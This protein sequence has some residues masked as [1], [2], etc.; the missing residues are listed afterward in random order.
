M[1]VAFESAL[2]RVFA[3]CEE[4]IS[5]HL[6]KV[7]ARSQALQSQD[8][9]RLAFTITEAIEEEVRA[10]LDESLGIYDAAINRPITPNAGWEK[11]LLKQV[12]YAVDGAVI[13][14][15][16]L[17]SEK[18]PWKPLLSEEAPKLRERLSA[19][20][21]AHFAELRKARKTRR[22]AAPTGLPETLVRLALFVGGVVVGAIA[23]NVIRL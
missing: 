13:Q 2:S 7:R 6:D 16:K 19:I 21:E 18:H 12:E 23:M 11:A 14:A 22:K 3:R 1:P 8:T 20:A 4:A 5:D 9:S 17:D 10:A 15:L